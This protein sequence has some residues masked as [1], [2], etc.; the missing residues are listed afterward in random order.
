MV[1][2]PVNGVRLPVEARLD[3]LE[4][5]LPRVERFLQTQAEINLKHAERATL[6]AREM[7]L[8]YVAA[9]ARM[10]RERIAARAELAAIREELD[11]PP[12]GMAVAHEGCIAEGMGAAG[13][14]FAGAIVMVVVL[15]VWWALS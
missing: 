12:P 4:V 10:K 15:V 7:R 3:N 8:L 6:H 11:G 9:Y 5:I 2:R 14:C 13:W 1:N